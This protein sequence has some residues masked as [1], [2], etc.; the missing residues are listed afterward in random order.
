[1]QPGN[2]LSQAE[3]AWGTGD[4]RA[5]CTELIEERARQIAL[6]SE[7]VCGGS[8]VEKRIGGDLPPEGP[9]LLNPFGRLVS[10]DDRGVDGANGDAGNPIWMNVGLRKGFVDAGLVGSERTAALQHQRNAFERETPFCRSEILL[11]L[12]VHRML[13]FS[14]SVTSR[15]FAVRMGT[16]FNFNLHYIGQNDYIVNMRIA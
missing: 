13:S 14:P 7:S 6:R 12:K 15:P 11:G 8:P 10:G 4:E 1:M 3:E 9:Q 2:G 5:G 16:G